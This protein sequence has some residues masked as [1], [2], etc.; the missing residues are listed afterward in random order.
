MGSPPTTYTDTYV[1]SVEPYSKMVSPT[2]STTPSLLSLAA[3]PQRVSQV[4]ASV[5]AAFPCTIFSNPVGL[6][7]LKTLV[8]IE[9]LE[10][11]RLAALEPKS[12]A[13]TNFAISAYGA[14]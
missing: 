13:S 5:W 1:N 9:G 8:R 3:P 2:F 12:S 4:T 14:A 7:T 10:P 6:K 11:P